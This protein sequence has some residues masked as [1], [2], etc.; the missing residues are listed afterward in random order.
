M[1]YQWEQG[2]KKV[3][4]AVVFH[5]YVTLSV[6]SN[7]LHLA[8]S[9][10]AEP[11]HGPAESCSLPGP[12]AILPLCTCGSLINSYMR[13]AKC[14][15]IVLFLLFGRGIGNGIEPLCAVS[16]AAPDPDE[17]PVCPA[18]QDPGLSCAILQTL[19]TG[20]QTVMHSSCVSSHVLGF[21]HR[22]S[23]QSLSARQVPKASL[24]GQRPFPRCAADSCPL[25]F[26]SPN[27]C[28][29]TPGGPPLRPVMPVLSVFLG[30]STPVLII[31]SFCAVDTRTVPIKYDTMTKTTQC[32]EGV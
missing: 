15:V 14:L 21:H 22:P 17:R 3:G 16:S 28:P 1:P 11:P 29:L 10:E 2:Q 24:S 13:I 8:E 23:G 25:S 7:Y 20:G 4:P 12:V 32:F 31:I 27:S 19:E 6:S 26:D 18:T 30:P 5:S 9:T